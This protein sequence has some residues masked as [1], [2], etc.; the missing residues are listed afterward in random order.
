M[1]HVYYNVLIASG[2]ALTGLGFGM[3][4]LPS[5]FIA[6]GL[7]VIVLTIIAAGLGGLK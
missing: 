1:N 5:A 6:V 4:H 3:I 2:V 7:L